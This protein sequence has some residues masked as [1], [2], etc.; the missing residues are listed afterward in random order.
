MVKSVCFFAA[1]SIILSTFLLK[2]IA[3]LRAAFYPKN[4][5]VI[6]QNPVFFGFTSSK[7]K[8]FGL[9]ESKT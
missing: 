2:K 5:L 7:P 9:S 3:A 6:F 4:V 1:K 8:H